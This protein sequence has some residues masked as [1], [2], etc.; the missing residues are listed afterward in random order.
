MR[1]CTPFCLFVIVQAYAT[2][3]CSET[4]QAL[5]IS[6]V[7]PHNCI[8]FLIVCLNSNF[9]CRGTLP[10]LTKV[11]AFGGVAGL[12]YSQSRTKKISSAEDI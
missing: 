1:N 11:V 8:C 12:A 7:S 4:Y 2:E 10:L 3:I 9:V 6:I 5:G